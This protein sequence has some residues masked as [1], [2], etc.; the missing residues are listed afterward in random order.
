MTDTPTPQAN[1]PITI[2]PFDNV[3]APGSP[4]RSD[5]PQQITNYA[6]DTDY[7][8]RTFRGVGAYNTGLAIGANGAALEM[9]H[10]TTLYDSGGFRPA[11]DSVNFVVPAELAGTYNVQAHVR[12]TAPTSVVNRFVITAGTYADMLWAYVPAFYTQV[13][14][15]FFVVLDAGDA[16]KLTMLNMEP[17]SQFWV[18]R[19]WLARVGP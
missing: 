7:Q 16:V 11:G 8:V 12:C 17:I 6:V 9:S 19:L 18:S 13:A 2:G 4:V 15:G 14:A 5:W 3:P 10:P 1:P